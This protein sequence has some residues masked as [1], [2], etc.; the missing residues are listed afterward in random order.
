M[1]WKRCKNSAHSVDVSSIRNQ[2]NRTFP[3]PPGSGATMRCGTHVIIIQEGGTYHWKE[4]YKLW[5]SQASIQL[6]YITHYGTL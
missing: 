3:V 6:V 2:R 1:R 5:A 4:V